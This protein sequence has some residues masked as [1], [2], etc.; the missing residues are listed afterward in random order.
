MNSFPVYR[1]IYFINFIVQYFTGYFNTCFKK[2]FKNFYK[3]Q[4][5]QKYIGAVL[6]FNI[7]FLRFRKL[8]FAYAAHGA[9]EIFREILEF[10][11][12]LDTVLGRAEFFIVFPSAYFTNVF[13]YRSSDLIYFRSY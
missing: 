2:P 8:I 13:H 6:L 4:R 1:D 12:G 11:A 10:R 5:R 9:L 3:K 7:C